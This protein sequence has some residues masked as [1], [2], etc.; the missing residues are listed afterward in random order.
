MYSHMRMSQL[1]A[2]QPNDSEQSHR[3]L[4]VA[5]HIVAVTTMSYLQWINE[6]TV[7]MLVYCTSK[8]YNTCDIYSMCITE[9]DPYPYAYASKQP[10]RLKLCYNVKHT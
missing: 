1:H 10:H 9:T 7:R 6:N 5:W 3:W 2:L 8:L 4:T